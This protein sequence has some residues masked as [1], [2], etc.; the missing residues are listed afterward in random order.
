[1]MTVSSPVE[2]ERTRLN[3]KVASVW[4]LVMEGSNSNAKTVSFGFRRHLSARYRNQASERVVEV[5]GY[6]SE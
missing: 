4:T 6:L 3:A 1:M 2:G 5:K